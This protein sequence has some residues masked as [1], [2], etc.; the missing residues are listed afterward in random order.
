LDAP[1][2]PERVLRAIEELCLRAV[3]PAARARAGE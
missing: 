3:E 1:A 2:T